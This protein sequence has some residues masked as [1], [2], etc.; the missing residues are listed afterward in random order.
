MGRINIIVLRFNIVYLQLLI[1]VSVFIF[2]KQN[3]TIVF[4]AQ[5]KHIVIMIMVVLI[6][7]QQMG[8]AIQIVM[9]GQLIVFVVE[10]KHIAHLQRFAK[11][12]HKP[13]G[14]A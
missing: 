5:I 14:S 4:V 12:K 7:L 3:F 11:N 2:A 10:I 9:M 6:N 1:L 8:Y 13:T